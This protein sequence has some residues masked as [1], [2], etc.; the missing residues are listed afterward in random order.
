LRLLFLYMKLRPI[1]IAAAT[2]L[3]MVAVLVIVATALLYYRQREL[4]QWAISQANSNFV[5]ELVIQDSRISLFH[6]FPYVDI[7]LRGVVFY[8]NKSK[9]GKPLYQVDDLYLGFRWWDV[10]RSNFDVRLIDLEGGHLDM[11][12]HVNGDINILRAKNIKSE[13]SSSADTS[14]VR[15]HLK[16][17]MVKDFHLSFFREVDSLKLETHVQ[18]LQTKLSLKDDH[19]FLKLNAASQLSI[20]LNGVPSFIFNKAITINTDLDYH[21]TD[22][23]LK[24]RETHLTLNEAKFGINGTVALADSLQ[25]D[26]TLFGEK[27]DF[28]LLTGLAP[29]AVSE[30]LRRYRNSGK[31]FFEGTIKGAFAENRQ[32]KLDF[33]FGCENGFFQNTST[34]KKVESLN[35]TGRLTNG[36]SQSMNT[37][38]F[39]LNDFSVKPGRGSFRGNLR[40]EN[41]NDPQVAVTLDSDLDLEFLGEF[42]GVEGLQ[43]LKG[44]IIVKMNFDELIDFENPEQSL[45]QLKKGIESE[46]SIRNLSFQIPGYQHPIEKLDLHALM[47]GGRVVMDT[48]L[49]RLS[50]SNL[51]LS[52]SISDL[53]ALFHQH[54]KNVTFRLEGSSDKINLFSLTKFDSASA[55]MMEEVISNF[56]MKLGFETSVR[57]LRH[58]PLPWGE[59]YIEDFYATVKG[60]P[61]ALHDLHTDVIINDTTFQLKN[62]SGEIDQSDFH[63]NGKLTNYNLW[64]DSVKYGDTRFEFDLYSEQLRLDNLLT[65]KGE[66]YLPEDYRHEIARE[67]KLHGLVDLN[68]QRKFRFAD[69]LMERMEARLNVH[70]LKVE[71]MKGRIHYQDE[72]ISIQN[73][74]ATLGASDVNLNLSYY[75]G[76][77]S[78][79]RVRDNLF[80]IR[81]N[82]LNLDQLLSYNP[83]PA[84]AKDHA[85]AFNIFEIPF[86]DMTFRA[87][88]Q[89]LKHHHVAITNLKVHARTKSNHYLFV[90]TLNMNLAGG[91][92]TMNGYLNGSNPKN[93]YFKNNANFNRLNLDQ[94][95]IKFDNFG[96][97]ML[98]SNNLHGQLTGTVNSVFLVHPDLTPILHEGEAHLD[99]A[100]ANG[101]LVNFAPL[102]AM[103]SFFRDRNLN[104]VRF[105][106]LR[107]KLDLAKGTLT[108]PAMTINSSLG[109]IEME[110]TQSL[111]LKMDY[112]IRVPLRLV[113][114][115]GFQSLFGGKRKEEVNPDQEDAIQY[116]DKDKRVRFINVRVS[117]TP[118]NFSFALG[119]RKK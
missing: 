45:A 26:V 117:G 59:F 115:V 94:L 84:K 56:R 101:S 52:G 32:P 33:R 99:I 57:K 70:P 88:I 8:P 92:F 19:L 102:Q 86:T 71:K 111:D 78:T 85:S 43:R 87:D 98:I 30:N 2:S 93:I 40:V 38:V 7:D 114:Q 46:L 15:I 60:Y 48:F 28:S 103:S 82:S 36:K 27:P 39:E 9:Q 63:F 44:N 58:S 21:L 107:N 23:K 47:Q 55:P 90:D 100:I 113:T 108:I 34:D 31:V 116:R 42:L 53:P 119:K 109:F 74:S 29:A 12:Q 54:E 18:E 67:L 3:G 4:T 73:L 1:L 17:F 35:F 64:F 105:D 25:L 62:F 77:H 10:L 104:N 106:T 5:G 49:L 51:Q 97:D 72:H 24:L 96:Q 22:Q 91:D 65:Y 41:F 13:S 50:D 80:S 112:L 95:L 66:S 37:M 75:T 61:H 6:D 89:S 68:F 83:S 110:G 20:F 14:T 79:L 11:I 69:L 118:E 76:R 16:K 81:S